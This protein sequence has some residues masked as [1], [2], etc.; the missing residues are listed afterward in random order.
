MQMDNGASKLSVPSFQTQEADN[1]REE[2]DEE[3]KM[4]ERDA[5][6]GC[7]D[8][9]VRDKNAAPLT[10]DLRGEVSYRYASPACM[11]CPF[12]QINSIL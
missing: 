7:R 12:S 3:G 1:E 10:N 5:E 9:Y 4:E 8:G 11:S 6:D 2:K